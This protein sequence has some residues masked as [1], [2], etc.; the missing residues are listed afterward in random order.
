MSKL[1]FSR[2]FL[3]LKETNIASKRESF[4]KQQSAMVDRSASGAG[5]EREIKRDR[6][7]YRTV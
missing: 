2:I 5:R 7:S 4:L 3:L 6:T 1:Q